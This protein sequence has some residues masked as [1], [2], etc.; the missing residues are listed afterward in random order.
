MYITNPDICFIFPGDLA[1]LIFVFFDPI[2]QALC[3]RTLN[4]VEQLNEKHAE[5]MRFYLSKADEAGHESDRQVGV[6]RKGRVTNMNDRRRFSQK[7]LN[8]MLTGI[9]QTIYLF[10]PINHAVWLLLLNL[11]SSQRRKVLSKHTLFKIV[12][13]ILAR[14]KINTPFILFSI[15][16]FT[17]T[18]YWGKL[19]KSIKSTWF[20]LLSYIFDTCR[21]FID[22][23]ISVSKKSL[24]H[25]FGARISNTCIFFKPCHSRF[26]TKLG[27]F[28]KYCNVSHT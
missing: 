23:L 9:H 4:L 17:N 11:N 12:Y 27:I 18:F 25:V 15:K 22:Q 13:F 20:I 24:A 8:I 3:K 1:D 6:N 5:R 2:G 10:F 28:G 26:I 19:P 14:F 21:L 7:Y 16:Y